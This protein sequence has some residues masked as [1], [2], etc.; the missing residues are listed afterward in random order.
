MLSLHFNFHIVSLR[1]KQRMTVVVPDF[2]NIQSVLDVCK[3]CDSCVL[4]ISAARDPEEWGDTLLSSVLGEFL[5]SG[6]HES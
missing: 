4:L 3:V 6:E 2:D 5:S 1:F